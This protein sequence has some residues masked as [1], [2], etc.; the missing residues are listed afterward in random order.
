MPICFV[1]LQCLNLLPQTDGGSFFNEVIDV[2]N[3][4][5]TDPIDLLNTAVIEVTTRYLVFVVL[6][7]VIGLLGYLIK[8]VLFTLKDAE[9]TSGHRLETPKTRQL[10]ITKF[11]TP[12]KKQGRHFL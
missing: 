7:I 5:H 10:K 1:L 3:V 12:I 9:I 6:L 11:V 4:G 2:Q 8:M